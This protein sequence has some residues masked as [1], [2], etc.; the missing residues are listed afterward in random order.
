[1]KKIV[2]IALIMVLLSG[3]GSKKCI[4]SHKE[5]DICNQILCF[6]SNNTIHCYPFVRPCERIVCDEY[7]ES[8]V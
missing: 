5:D 6:P 2:I 4:K 1:M 7:E 3:C 8:Q